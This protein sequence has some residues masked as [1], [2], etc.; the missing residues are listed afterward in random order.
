MPQ[1]RNEL[2]PDV[3]ELMFMSGAELDNG[4]RGKRPWARGQ[5]TL[6]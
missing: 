1:P 2:V 6:G 5:P 4:N 3:E